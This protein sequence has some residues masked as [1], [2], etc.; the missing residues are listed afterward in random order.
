MGRILSTFSLQ[1][2]FLI[3][4]NERNGMKNIGKVNRTPSSE[5]SVYK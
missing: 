3:D 5:F 1:N 4:E 2:I